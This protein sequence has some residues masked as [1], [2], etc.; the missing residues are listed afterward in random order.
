[1]DEASANLSHPRTLVENAYCIRR[2][3]VIHW[4]NVGPDLGGTLGGVG[5]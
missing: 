5:G 4:S 1:M 3:A 2:M